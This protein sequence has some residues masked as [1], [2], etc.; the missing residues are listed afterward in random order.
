LQGPILQ[1]EKAKI[2][3]RLEDLRKLWEATRC[4]VM[5]NGW[6]DGKGRALLNFLVH[7]P[8]S[9]LFIKSID[10]SAQVKNKASLFELLDEFVQKVGLQHVVQLI[11]YNATKYVVVNKLLM[12]RQPILFC[13]F[14]THC[15]NL[16]LESVG[17]ISFIKEVIDQVR[18]IP[19]YRYNHAFVLSLMRKFTGNKELLHPT[20][21][22]FASNVIYL[23]SLQCCQFEVK[24]MFVSDE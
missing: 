22:H 5:S 16:M 21:T 6:M 19:K 8:R 24:Q 2:N 23:K 17:K 9:T 4:M 12:E 14:A 1:K 11:T 13:P 10:A 7:F 20:I 18:R 15:I 3:T